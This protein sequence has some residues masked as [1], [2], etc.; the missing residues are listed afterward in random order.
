MSYYMFEV[1]LTLGPSSKAM[2][3]LGDKVASSIVA[4]TA[5]IPTLP[6]SGSG[7]TLLPALSHLGCILVVLF[8]YCIYCI[9][10]H[11]AAGLRVDWAEE[12]QTQGIII[13]VPSEIYSKG[14][15]QDVDEGLA[16]RSF[17]KIILMVKRLP[18]GVC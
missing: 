12:D 18:I 7:D 16:V 10:C 8:S 6:W 14:C 17:I 11:T 2:W 15:V 5:G 4:Q 9:Y 13:S 3:A 1:S